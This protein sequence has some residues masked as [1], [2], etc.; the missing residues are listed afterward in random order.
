MRCGYLWEGVVALLVWL[1]LGWSGGCVINIC[2][3][4]VSCAE[5]LTGGD[6]ASGI[7]LLSRDLASGIPLRGLGLRHS[8]AGIGAPPFPSS[9]GFGFIAFSIPPTPLPRGPWHNNRKKLKRAPAR[10][11]WFLYTVIP[12]ASKLVT[13]CQ[14]TKKALKRCLRAF[15]CCC[16]VRGG[17][18]PIFRTIL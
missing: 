14:C 17:L 16:A 3:E 1:L 9:S 10:P 18:L 7:S 2:V 8:P 6:W 4:W 11:T 5:V 13:V 12:Y 15:F